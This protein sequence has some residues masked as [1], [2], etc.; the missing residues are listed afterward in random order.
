MPTDKHWASKQTAKQDEVRDFVSR[1]LDQ[2][3]SRTE[4]RLLA[5]GQWW[6]RLPFHD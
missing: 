4:H 1:G 5:A 2:F 3:C 6:C